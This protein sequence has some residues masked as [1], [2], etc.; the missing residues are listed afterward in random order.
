M[1]SVC[2]SSRTLWVKF[3]FSRVKVCFGVVYGPNEGDVE[4]TESLRNNVDRF[5][6]RV[7][8]EYRLCVLK[9]LN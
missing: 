3:K 9:E 4:E 8:S 1:Q 5:V 6:D 7:G 2:G